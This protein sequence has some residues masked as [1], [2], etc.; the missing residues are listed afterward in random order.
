MLFLAA[1]DGSVGQLVLLV[2]L[3]WAGVWAYLLRLD[4]RLRDWWENRKIDR[5]V[6]RLGRER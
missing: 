2:V 1:T 3:L 6:R 5:R 4:L